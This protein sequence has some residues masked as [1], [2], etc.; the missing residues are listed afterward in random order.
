M[1]NPTGPAL[2]IAD[3]NSPSQELSTH[4]WFTPGRVDI[5]VV[6]PV[7]NFHHTHRHTESPLLL[8]LVR[9]LSRGDRSLS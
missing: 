1:L 6:M 8:S 9:S 5:E 2:E 4:M 7:D 3:P